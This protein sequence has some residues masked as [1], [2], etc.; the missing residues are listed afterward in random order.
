MSFSSSGIPLFRHQQS[1]CY[2]SGL[3][4]D[5]P[6]YND[7]SYYTVG[8]T[9]LDDLTERDTWIWHNFGFLKKHLSTSNP[10]LLVR[11]RAGK[12]ARVVVRRWW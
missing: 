7:Y 10:R 5:P 2:P 9:I 3:A 11:N 6:R 8:P 1:T 12:A 4:R